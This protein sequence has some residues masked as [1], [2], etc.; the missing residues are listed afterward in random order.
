M[1]VLVVCVLPRRSESPA[2]AF[3][4]S[5]WHGAVEN[6]TVTEELAGI[7]SRRLRA[8]VGTAAR[9]EGKHGFSASVDGMVLGFDTVGSLREALKKRQSATVSVVGG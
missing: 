4:A 5:A 7:L 3:R 8:V 6:G 9:P 1:L 2:D